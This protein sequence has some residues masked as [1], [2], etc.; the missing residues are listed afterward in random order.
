MQISKVCRQFTTY[1]L[2]CVSMSRLIFFLVAVDS[3]NRL[4]IVL[5]SDVTVVFF[6]Q[7]Y[8]CLAKNAVNRAVFKQYLL[9]FTKNEEFS[10]VYS[11][12]NNGNFNGAALYRSPGH[13]K[14]EKFCT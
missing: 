3:N 4:I 5:C 14:Y 7:V 6:I 10:W 11:S 2:L 1:K 9:Y 13:H 8:F 12:V